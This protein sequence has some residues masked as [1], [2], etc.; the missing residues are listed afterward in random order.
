MGVSTLLIDDGETSLMVDGF[1]SRPSKWMLLS[2]RIGPDRGRI[3]SALSRINVRN[4]AAVLVAHSHHDHALD[5]ASVAATT[6]ALLIG[7]TSVSN[8]A[9]GEGLPPAQIQVTDS[10][11]QHVFGKFVV[12]T[13]LSPHSPHGFFRGKILAPLRPPA[14]VS[15][16][17][18]GSN[19][20]YLF[21]HPTCTVLVHP[22]ANFVHGMF[23]G[24]SADVVFLGVGTLGR[25]K[26]KF[27]TDYWSEVVLATGAKLVVPIHWDDFTIPLDQPLKPMPFLFDDSDRGMA[28][29]ARMAQR[30]K[31]EVRVLSAF[32]SILLCE[33]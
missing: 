2:S 24:V 29:I 6:K 19:F 26:E 9:R 16:Y 12:R 18:G 21:S 1:F 11:N 7:S 3:G 23:R 25:R 27:C 10:G 22:S 20:S 32:E 31:V 33:D 14:R 30:D 8:I 15:A 13:V 17:R 5:A 28:R 4:V